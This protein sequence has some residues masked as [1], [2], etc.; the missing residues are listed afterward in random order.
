MVETEA[1][2]AVLFGDIR[3]FTAYT[4]HAGDRQALRLARRFTELVSA[5]VGAR[6]G[7]IVKT[8]GDGVMTEFPDAASA[9]LG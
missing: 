4:A 7:R 5:E 6:G 1:V 8:Y 2:I 9:A 3:G